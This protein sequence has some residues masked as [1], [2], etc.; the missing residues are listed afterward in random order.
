MLH[1]Y[2]CL[3]FANSN[4]IWDLFFEKK[5]VLSDLSKN[6]ASFIGKMCS[7]SADFSKKQILK[8]SIYAYLLHILSEETHKLWHC[9][10]GCFTIESPKP[11]KIMMFFRR[12]LQGAI[13]YNLTQSP[14]WHFAICFLLQ[15]YVGVYLSL[16]VKSLEIIWFPG[17][18]FA[19]KSIWHLPQNSVW[20]SLFIIPFKL[21]CFH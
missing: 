7:L 11:I 9:R 14:K 19:G 5:K 8:V 13:V 4:A 2:I 10:K 20:G 21:N 16:T 3:D 12:S 1:H 17:M 18:F 15:N 6:V